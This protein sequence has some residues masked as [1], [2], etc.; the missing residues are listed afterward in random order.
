MTDTENGAVLDTDRLRLRPLQAAD[1]A[2]IATGIGEWEVAKWLPVLP[3]PYGLADAEGFI[4]DAVS[5]GALVIEIAGQVAGVV[6]IGAGNE[7]GY[8]LARAFHGRGYM[9][10]AASAL[11][12]RHFARGGGDLLSGYLL[13]NGPSCNV[14]TKLGFSN[15]HVERRPSRPRGEDVDIQRMV[16]TA[17]GWAARNQAVIATDWLRLRALRAGDAA[18]IAAGIGDWEVM[19]WLTTP[20]WPYALGDAEW[21]IGDAASDGAWG[22]EVA[23]ELAGI[24]SINPDRDLGYWL[25]QRFHGHGYMTEAATAL[26]ARHFARGGGDLISGYL[27]G[28]GPSCNVLTKLG[29]EDTHVERS[30]SRP[31]GEDVDIQRMVL[32]AEAWA[33]RHPLVIRTARLVL[34]PLTDDDAAALS[35]M[36]V[37][38]VARMMSTVGAPWSLDEVRDWIAKSRW[39]GCP[40]FRLGICLADGTLVGSAG[41]GGEPLGCAYFLAP[42]HW[43]RG[44]ATEAM[45]A[46]LADAFARFGL[47]VIEAEAFLDNPASLRVLA[48]LGFKAVADGIGTSQARLEPAPI[49]LYRLTN[50]SLQAS[51]HEIP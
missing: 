9:T 1:A 47:S 15:T 37:P 18:A 26:V 40:G 30:L 19:Q 7:L 17:A 11:V 23:G 45:R 20:P 41:L 13:G 42:A 39:R 44:Y 24:V 31:R 51:A 10:E 27:L 3:W 5:D 35:A 4:G 12:A 8:W 43:G 32:S 16:L 21:F 33:T 49:R 2:A 22:I 6:H 48:K 38:Q 25:A 34:R 36:G 14:L 28:N 50:P 46:L 29:F